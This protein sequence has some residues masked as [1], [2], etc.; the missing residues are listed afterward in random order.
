MAPVEKDDLDLKGCEMTYANL[1]PTSGGGGMPK[2][3]SLRQCI[4]QKNLAALVEYLFALILILQCRSIYTAEEGSPFGKLLRVAIVGALAL[5][6]VV[7]H[8]I[9]KNNLGKM[10]LFGV[11][12]VIYF[13]IYYLAVN[14]NNSSFLY[15][16]MCV[17]SIYAFL[18]FARENNRAIGILYKFENLIVV[19]AVV[20]LF[21]WLFGSTLG[22]IHPTGTIRS[23]WSA[24]GVI[25][26]KPSYF[27]IYF[28]MQSYGDLK[29][30]T[31]LFTEAPMSSFQFSLA[32]LVELFCR[33]KMSKPRVVILFLAILSTISTT[34]WCVMIIA[35]FAKF[36]FSRNIT[37]FRKIAKLILIP[38]ALIAAVFVV[39]MLVF[40]KLDTG[41]G[42]VRTIDFLVGFQAFSEKP[43]FG[44]GYG[45]SYKAFGR[46]GGSNSLSPILIQGGLFFLIPYLVWIVLWIRNCILYKSIRWFLFIGCFLF[47]FLITITPMQ[48]LS[49]FVL[50]GSYFLISEDSE[51]HRHKIAAR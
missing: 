8:K 18:V 46:G 41:S 51:L 48:F 50:M 15:L 3:L 47:M 4:S 30:N 49:L 25:R 27:N 24:S 12:L 35:I 16:L 32:F 17:F 14:Y 45:Y 36:L 5:Y 26:I 2:S 29:R 13:L 6:V 19:I 20:S 43:L 7:W 9:S 23:T 44:Y 22:I 40:D 21:F 11:G 37:S 34:G 28:E 33:K 38:I 31:A 10:F 1:N 39:Q 42:R